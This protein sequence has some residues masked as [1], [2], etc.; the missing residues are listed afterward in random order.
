MHDGAYFIALPFRSFFHIRLPDISLMH[1]GMQSFFFPT[2][3]LTGLDDLPQT[4][5]EVHRKP[6][7]YVL[8]SSATSWPEI[9]C[10]SHSRQFNC[11]LSFGNTLDYLSSMTLYFPNLCYDS[12]DGLT[13]NSGVAVARPRVRKRCVQEAHH[14]DLFCASDIRRPCGRANY[15][16]DAPPRQGY[17][18]P[19]IAD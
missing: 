14:S 9:N 15:S 7:S 8:R 12:I 18:P 10:H 19:S 1:A 6:F 3:N 11:L 4:M 5:I 2:R 16:C 17:A 13:P